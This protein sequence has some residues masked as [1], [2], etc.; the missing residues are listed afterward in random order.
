MRSLPRCLPFCRSQTG[1]RV[2]LICAFKGWIAWRTIARQYVTMRVRLT[3]VGDSHT[4][5]AF[6]S[7][8]SQFVFVRERQ[9]CINDGG[10]LHFD[11]TLMICQSI[12]RGASILPL[13]DNVRKQKSFKMHS[14]ITFDARRKQMLIL[15]QIHLCSAIQQCDIFEINSPTRY[16]WMSI[17][18]FQ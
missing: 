6:Y 11:S 4:S 17:F 7:W 9:K 18:H 13:R 2:L 10:V 1:R 16:H 8:T 12:T 15:N 5:S 14:S 3:I